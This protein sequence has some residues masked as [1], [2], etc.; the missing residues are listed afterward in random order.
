MVVDYSLMPIDT[1]G[2]DGLDDAIIGVDHSGVQPVLKYDYNK[3]CQILIDNNPGWDW[4]GAIEWM[5]ANVV[6]AYYGPGTPVFCYPDEDGDYISD[7]DD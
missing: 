5:E 3:C 6:C 7:E 1:M 4:L 2:P